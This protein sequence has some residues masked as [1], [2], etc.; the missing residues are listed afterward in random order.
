VGKIILIDSAGIYFRAIHSAGRQLLLK[1]EGKL[2][3][4]M[5]SVYV[6]FTILISILKK[7]H[8][9][10]DDIVIFG[11]EGK[12]WR[13][14]YLAS[15]KSQREDLR[16][17]YPHI[18]WEK[19]WDEVNKFHE[20]LEQSTSFFFIREWSSECDD[21]L[22]TATKVFADKECIIVSGDGD[23]KMLAVRPNV[24]F[25][26]VNKKF[27][28][29]KGCYEEI[30]NG[31]KILNDKIKKGDKSDNILVNDSEDEYET[32][33]R[34]KIVDLLNIPE[35]IEKKI[36]EKLENLELKDYDLSKIPYAGKNLGKRFSQIFDPQYKITYEECINPKK[37]AKV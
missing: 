4:A 24:K 23:L 36:I 3:F 8:V 17:K 29:T 26:S 31:Y 22:A 18:N 16:K 32:Q 28:G 34:K 15:Y 11:L 14:N 30:Q 33:I 20:Q 13:K 7:I 1:K 25:F 27:K 35:E 9:E 6:Y 2:K 5:S 10:L 37:K 21:I 12:S 19:E